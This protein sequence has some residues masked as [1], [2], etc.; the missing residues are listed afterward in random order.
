[1]QPSSF[2]RFRNLSDF[3]LSRS[4][5]LK[6]DSAIGLPIWGLLLMYNS[7]I[8]PNYALTNTFVEKVLF[9][10]CGVF[11]VCFVVQFSRL[12]NLFLPC[13]WIRELNQEQPATHSRSHLV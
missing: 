6:F 7:G 9:I 8:W 3:D 10:T 12:P 5:K 1:M 2:T 11:I 4:L 13:F